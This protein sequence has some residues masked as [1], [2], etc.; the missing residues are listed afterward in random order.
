MNAWVDDLERKNFR[1][2]FHEFVR[3]AVGRTDQEQIS[4]SFQR[5][6]VMFDKIGDAICNAFTVLFVVVAISVPLAL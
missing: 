2:F 1:W 6:I 5:E 3:A 4:S